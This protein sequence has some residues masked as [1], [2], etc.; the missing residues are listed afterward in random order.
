MRKPLVVYV[1]GAPGS[2][3][4]TLAKRIAAE[5]Y[6]PHVSSDLVHGGVRLTEG[7]HDRKATIHTVFVPLLTNM[8]KMNISFVVDHVLQ[9]NLSEGDIVEKIKPHAQLVYV[10][11]FADNAIERFYQRELSRTDRGVVLTEEQLAS[12]RDF[13]QKNLLN[14]QEPL[15]LGVPWIAVEANDDYKPSFDKIV[16][17]I[18]KEYGGE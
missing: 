4:T 11:V 1:S 16:A 14:T 18:D 5:F 17:F 15:E 6:I 13:H 3:K 12:R 8:A 9:R 2:G 10:H 7:T